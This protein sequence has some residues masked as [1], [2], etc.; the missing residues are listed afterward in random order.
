M[1]PAL[2]PTP[3]V[4]E[5]LAVGRAA[6]PELSAHLHDC[7]SCRLALEQ[8]REN[9]R[10]LA[11]FAIGG[12]LPIAESSEPTFEIDIPGY[13]MV[14]RIHQGGQGVVYQAI[15][16]ST[17]RDVAI[18][19]MKQGRFAT[20]AD[21]ARF[22]REIDT[23]GGLNHPNIVAVHDAGVASGFQY[24]VMNYVDG[25]PLDEA[26]AEPASPTGV[27]RT[28]AV[29]TTFV[30]VCDAV[31]AAHLRGI[32]HR[33]L[34]PSNIRVDQR[35][36]PHVLDFGLA[37]SVEQQ[38]DS[39]M[40]Q[41]GQF[42]GSL[43][44]ASPEQIEGIPSRIDLRTDVY[45]LGAILY[46]LLTG[47]P[48]F[49]VGSSLRTAFELILLRDPP[50]PSVA[51]ASAGAP[52]ID[53]E[54][55]TMVMKCLSKD[56]ERR[57]QIAG[58]IANDLRR[59]IA[60]EPIE[61]KRD[62]AIYMLRKTLRR[63]RMRVAV[64][65]SF[66]VLIGVFAVVMAFL[67]QRS[68][69]LEQEAVQSA[70]RMAELLSQS[71]IEQGRMAD[72]LGN[73]EQAEQL[74]WRELLLRSTPQGATGATWNEPPGPPEAYWALWELYRRRPC[75]RT[76]RP[77]PEPTRT[78]TIAR[79]GQSIWIVDPAG[80][81]QRLDESGVRLESYRVTLPNRIGF[82]KLN[83]SGSTLINYDGTRFGIWRHDAGD[84]RLM[85]LPESLLGLAESISPRGQRL[86]VVTDG[87]A[88][89][90][91]TNPPAEIGR[92]SGDAAVVAVAVSNDDRKLATRD[93]W[94]AVALWD[95]D[96]G[97]C[98]AH[99]RPHVPPRDRLH[100]IGELL[101][102]PDDR[103][104]A[105]AWVE[106]PG[107]VWDFGVSPPAVIEL[108]ERPGDY[109]VQCFSPDGS[110]LAIGDIG[111]A[112]RVFDARTGRRLAGFVAHPG[113]ISSVAFTGD[114]AGV[115]TCS[116]GNLRLWQ[117]V[118]DQF[119]RT[120][121]LEGDA[122]HSVD[123]DPNGSE[124]AAGGGQGKLIRVNRESGQ[125]S[126]LHF[127]NDSTISCVA[128]SPD[129]SRIAAATYGKVVYVWNSGDPSAEPEQL[130]HPEL[131]NH[132]HFTPDS[133]RLAS[134]DDAGTI[135]IWR[136]ADAAIERE[137]NCGDQR[138][139]RIDLNAD[140]RKIAAAVRD[141]RLMVWDL[142][143][144]E[145]ETLSPATDRALRTVRFSG[146]GRWLASAGADRTIDLWD[147]SSRQRVASLVG[148][149]QEVYDVDISPDGRLIA[150][151]D[152]GGVIRLWDARLRR[153]LATFEGHSDA[154]MT[155]QFSPD[156]RSLV[157]VSLDGTIRDRD[158]GYF[159]RHIAGQVD[160]Q[161]QRIEGT[162]GDES[163]RAAW[164]S[165]ARQ[166]LDRFTPPASLSSAH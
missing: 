76:L 44:W 6:P 153:Q 1:Q 86:A 94:G 75:L 108:S 127:G 133:R 49:D 157:S 79:D 32:I 30:K 162:N 114:G 9:N 12:S 130:V 104:V 111:G 136:L 158:L 88:S 128:F 165:W 96:T 132:V 52:P 5:D 150:S 97:E 154:V 10:F 131:V 83:A 102:S 36:E 87:T 56:R 120:V 92:F 146:D 31:H 33:D 47:Q 27:D 42:V 60:G 93:R 71:N 155:L 152:T 139:P 62:S 43:P 118:A 50:R 7:E 70:S 126:S 140:G 41:T 135:R 24:F 46:Q 116:E 82:P 143:T 38:P 103:L 28:R 45:S 18:K 164:R 26:F 134:A 112:L 85:A 84:Q 67:Y 138:I 145:V 99:A 121:R 144:G 11:D 35:G 106:I 37:K 34:K 81:V 66:V 14:R 141:G 122:L 21:R 65:G 113:R 78:V 51:A 61:A 20:L 77:Q 53:D 80:F 124:L 125:K 3:E 160:F 101:F 156:S 95:I 72:V 19:V 115:W 159:D 64:A 73:M 98:L 89:V 117:V 63:Y 39:A 54:L 69:R 163:A 68:N 59:Y 107:R 142:E 105:D 13:D 110:M 100:I 17:R 166:V 48:P 119:V 29:L 161:L 57:Y 16:R 25:Q 55:D 129:S 40:T 8:I 149:S 147:V 148:H 58:E 90:W 74:L 109:R 4:L 137:L 151:G 23:L 15:Q 123:I 91:N 22:E 2:C